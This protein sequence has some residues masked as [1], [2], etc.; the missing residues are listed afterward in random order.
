MIV[1]ACGNHRYPCGIEQLR[2]YRLRFL[3]LGLLN[4][5]GAGGFVLLLPCGVCLYPF[6]HRV[7]VRRFRRFV[8]HDPKGKVHGNRRQPE[9]GAFPIATIVTHIS[10]SNSQ[11][12]FADDAHWS[13][14]FHRRS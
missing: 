10:G 2:L 13:D 9:A 4:L 1:F 3:F 5:L 7:L 12:S 8:T 14:A 6:L 11:R